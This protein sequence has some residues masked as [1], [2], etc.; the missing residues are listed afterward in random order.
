MGEWENGSL[1]GSGIIFD[2]GG[3][4]ADGRRKRGSGIGWMLWLAFFGV[5]CK[6]V[7]CELY[8]KMY[9]SIL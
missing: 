7:S 8:R 9:I 1:D 3:K 4:M 5:D 2:R 6:I